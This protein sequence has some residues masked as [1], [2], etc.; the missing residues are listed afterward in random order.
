MGYSFFHIIMYFVSASID[1]PEVSTPHKI[2]YSQ[3]LLMLDPSKQHQVME[4]QYCPL[5][6]VIVSTKAKHHSTCK[7]P[8]VHHCQWLKTAAG[9]GITST[10]GS[11]AQWPLPG[12]LC[13]VFILLYVFIQYLNLRVLQGMSTMEMLASRT[14]GC[15]SHYIFIEKPSLQCS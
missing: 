1:L 11:S 5:S 10:G 3:L 9:A 2:T 4:N 15:C 12:L 14:C 6:E 8:S 7:C 13:L